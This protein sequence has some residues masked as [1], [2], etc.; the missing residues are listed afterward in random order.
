MI[1]VPVVPVFPSIVSGFGENILSDT[2]GEFAESQ[3][4]SLSLQKAWRAFCSTNQEEMNI[5][6]T[7]EKTPPLP[8]K[9]IRGIECGGEHRWSAQ[10]T[11]EIEK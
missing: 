11:A 8:R 5:R 4:S 9:R 1:V 3:T 6:G 10:D 2:D 7:P